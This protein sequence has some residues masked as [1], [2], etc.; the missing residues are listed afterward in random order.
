M[1]TNSVWVV[2]SADDAVD[3]LRDL[4]D[5]GYFT[6]SQ[7]LIYEL[8]AMCDKVKKLVEAQGGELIFNAY[9]RI[10]LEVPITVAEQMPN[11]LEGYKQFFGT[12]LACGI[13]L[14]FAEASA[15]SRKSAYSNEIELFDPKDPSFKQGSAF[16]KSYDDVEYALPPN[17]FDPQ[18]PPDRELEPKQDDYVPPPDL[19]QQVEGETALIQTIIQQIGG[20][21]VQQMQQQMQEQMQGNPEEQGPRDLLEALHGEQIPGRET[22]LNENEGGNPEGAPPEDEEGEGEEEGESESKDSGKES[23]D[24][25]EDEGEDHNAKLGK[26]LATVKQQL[27]QLMQLAESNPDAFKQTMSMVHKLLAYAKT[28][29]GSTKKSNLFELTDE[30]N[31]AFR[32]PV[33]TR[34]GKYKKVKE[35][36]KE[37][38]RQMSAGQVLD[39]KGQAISVRQ[40]NARATS[41]TSTE[42]TKQSNG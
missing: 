34:K 12:K 18:Q 15:A 26:L 41:S 23:E 16:Y 29:K 3:K 8:Q 25:G 24:E 6:E 2:I 14:T 17:L 36:N 5:K 33:G 21:Q 30:L 31:K 20:Q 40:S 37:S 42:G 22:D 27:P 39:D 28:T 1:T 11:I 10:V 13:G 4:I 38:W 7:G 32:W 9:E 35:N 19:K